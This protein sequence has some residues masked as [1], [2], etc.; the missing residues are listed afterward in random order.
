ME[1]NGRISEYMLSTQVHL[2]V[3]GKMSGKVE[4]YRKWKSLNTLC[5]RLLPL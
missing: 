5:N 1:Q 2:N 4:E 3:M